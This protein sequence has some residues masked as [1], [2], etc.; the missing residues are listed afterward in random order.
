MGS[1]RYIQRETRETEWRFKEIWARIGI[2]H[3]ETV[4]GKLRNKNTEKIP[5]F[6]KTKAVFISWNAKNVVKFICVRQDVN[7]NADWLTIKAEKV[8]EQLV[9]YTNAKHF[10]EENHR[11]V[12]LI[13]NFENFKVVNSAVELKLEEKLGVSEDGV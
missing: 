3:C 1:L 8:T 13:L 12:N 2:K 9:H 5:K 6:F 7:M 11:F 10:M 4:F